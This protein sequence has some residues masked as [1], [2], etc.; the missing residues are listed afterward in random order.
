MDEILKLAET[1]P[2]NG[3]LLSVEDHRSKS[4]VVI[5]LVAD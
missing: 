3:I 2:T 5:S 1:P 4:R